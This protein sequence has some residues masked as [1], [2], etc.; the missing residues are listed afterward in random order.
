LFDSDNIKL[1]CEYDLC[2]SKGLEIPFAKL[3][4]EAIGRVESA[5]PRNGFNIINLFTE[6]YAIEFQNYYGKKTQPYKFYIA[7]LFTD[8]ALR[9]VHSGKGR[10]YACKFHPVIAHHF[11]KISM[12]N[13]VDKQVLLTDLLP[14]SI[15]L[16]QLENDVVNHQR[17]VK[18]MNK[19]FDALLP[20]KEVY[21]KDP[22]YHIV[23]FIAENKGKVTTEDIT[24]KFHVAERTLNRNFLRKVGL[25]FK[26]YAKIW[27][28]E[29][30][31]LHIQAHPDKSLSSI[32]FDCGYYDVAHLVKDFQS[33]MHCAP[34][35]LRQELTP[36]LESYLNTQGIT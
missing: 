7:G 15:Y 23:N 19:L 34:T 31:L 28:F 32:A 27:Q 29:N 13:L 1:K 12:K 6:D 21:Q 25:S 36:M 35:S 30:A 4:V 17:D 9:V 2:S 24:S 22:M 11:L 18:F 20:E 16:K 33:Y 10:G 8:V 14:D 3:D 26:S 5:F